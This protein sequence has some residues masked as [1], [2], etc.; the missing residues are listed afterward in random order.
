MIDDV[1]ISPGG[2]PSDRTIAINLATWGAAVAVALLIA[3]TDPGAPLAIA[4][5]AGI[6]AIAPALGWLMQSIDR[7]ALWLQ[8]RRYRGEP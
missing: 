7:V 6:V 5:L 3:R 1:S 2:E 4:G 8:T